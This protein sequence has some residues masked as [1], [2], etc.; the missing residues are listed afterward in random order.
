MKILVNLG[1]RGVYWKYV[2]LF[3][4]GWEG[5]ENNLVKVSLCIGMLLLEFYYF[6]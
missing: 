5:W 1:R 6:F 4:N 2:L 3:I